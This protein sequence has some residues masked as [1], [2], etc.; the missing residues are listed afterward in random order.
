MSAWLCSEQHVNIIVNAI[1]GNAKDFKM[2][3]KENLRS[4][5]ARYPG[6]DFL[7]DW[8]NDVKVETFAFKSAAPGD[9]T[10]VIKSCDSFDYQACETD[11]YK[12]TK[13]ATFVQKVRT[14]AI[15]AGGKSEG[16][17]YDAAEW[18]L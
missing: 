8:K 16:P 17:Q 18:S 12:S 13:A 2:L 11:D 5:E 1:G 4:L 9:M 3:V 6:R 15:A 14:H 10:Q 7:Q